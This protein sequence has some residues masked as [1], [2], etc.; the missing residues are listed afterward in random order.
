MKN[1]LSITF[2]IIYATFSFGQEKNSSYTEKKIESGSTYKKYKNGKLDSVVVSMFAVN[3][4]NA[5]IFSKSNDEIQM[6]NSADTEAVVT[7]KLQGKK[8][9]KTFLYQNKPVVIQESIDFVIKNLPKNAI[10][11]SAIYNE[12]VITYNISTDYEV[13]G[14]DSHDKIFKVF[15]RLNIHPGLDNLGEIFENIADFFSEDDALLKIFY[16]S[17]AEKF[18]PQP[19]AYLQTDSLGKIKEGIFLDF[20]NRKLNDTNEYHIYKDGKIIKSENVSLDKFQKII[21]AYLEKLDIN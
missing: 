18:E 5:L 11:T 17:Y 21:M 13:L 10:V 16:G 15:N 19:L 14:D 3:H 20:K 7:I 12:N 8:Q 4:S 9:V 1:I 2:I 6:I